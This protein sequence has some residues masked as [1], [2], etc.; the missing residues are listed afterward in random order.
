VV[1]CFAKVNKNF[2]LFVFLVQKCAKMFQKSL[3][4]ILETFSQND[5]TIFKGLSVAAE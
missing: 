1:N 3:L 4:D 5:E 2:V